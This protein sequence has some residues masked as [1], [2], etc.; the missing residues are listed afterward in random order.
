LS[1]WPDLESDRAAS[2]TLVDD[3]KLV[4][5]CD[6]LREIIS[7]VHSVRKN[8]SVRVRQ[9]L[10]Q[11]TILIAQ[12]S[13]LNDYQDL[14][15]QELN[16]KEVELINL[17]SAEKMGFQIQD[18]LTI[19]ARSLG[20]RI[21]GRVQAVIQ[22]AKAGNWKVEGNQVLVKIPI[23]SGAGSDAPAS[24]A[25]ETAT[26]SD[27]STP[28]VSDTETKSENL[29]ATANTLATSSDISVPAASATATSSDTS[30]PKA[31]VPAFETVELTPEDYNL[32]TEVVLPDSKSQVGTHKIPG[33]GFVILDLEITSELEAEGYVRDLIR[34]IQDLRKDQG[35]QVAD[36][37]SLK[38]AVPSDRVNAIETHKL[39]IKSETL[40]ELVEVRAIDSKSSNT[41][42]KDTSDIE[43]TKSH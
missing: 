15:K 36:R 17:A 20:P 9:P 31:T 5:T 39:L 32:E 7:S 28:A 38:L 43:I 22:N 3:P 14:I 21:G 19:N 12:P 23:E 18:Q 10:A 1:D 35:L 42:A 4:E 2:L 27:I 29:A 16:V 37:I 26:S 41:A 13:D 6:L 30:A 24:T 11:L 33:G 25:R 34:D 8:H 40:A